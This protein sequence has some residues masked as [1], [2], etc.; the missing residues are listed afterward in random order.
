M[1]VVM[2]AHFTESGDAGKLRTSFPSPP[3]FVQF[4]FIYSHIEAPREVISHVLRVSGPNVRHL[5]RIHVPYG[6]QK[7]RRRRTETWHT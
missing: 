1:P 4:N 5:Y 3:L 2:S 7:S 6:I